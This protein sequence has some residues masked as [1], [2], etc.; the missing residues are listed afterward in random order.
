MVI[1]E[2]GTR[3]KTVSWSHGIIHPSINLSIYLSIRLSILDGGV[4]VGAGHFQPLTLQS[5]WMSVIWCVQSSKP[6]N[7]CNIYIYIYIYI[8]LCVCVCVCFVNVV[9]RWKVSTKQFPFGEL[10]PY[11]NPDAAQAASLEHS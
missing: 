7:S 10:L 9:G 5:L 2:T 3:L 4:L 11:W 8:Y 1:Q 6:Q